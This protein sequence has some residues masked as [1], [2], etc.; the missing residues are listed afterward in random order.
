MTVNR[1]AKQKPRGKADDRPH[2]RIDD[3]H[4]EQRA[5]RR[6]GRERRKGAHMADR[7]HDAADGQ[8]AEQEAGEI[9]RAHEADGRRRKSPPARRASAISVPCRPL[10]PSRMPAAMRSGISGRMED[11]EAESSRVGRLLSWSHTPS[12]Q[13]QR[14]FRRLAA[15]RHVAPLALTN[16]GLSCAFRANFRAGA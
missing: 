15:C 4:Q 10:P 14:Q 8:A 3:Q 5:G 13:C 16:G 6:D 1:P 2:H 12:A 9:G 11:M 7:L